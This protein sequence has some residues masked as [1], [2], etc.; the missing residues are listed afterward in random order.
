MNDVNFQPPERRIGDKEWMIRFIAF[1]VALVFM[2][3]G[4]FL[5]SV[6]L[7]S[8]L[9]ASISFG[10]G[11]IGLAGALFVG[12]N[13]FLKNRSN[14]RFNALSPSINYRLK[15]EIK[16][17][18]ASAKDLASFVNDKDRWN[19]FIKP[20]TD[21][22]NEINEIKRLYNINID[23]LYNDKLKSIRQSLINRFVIHYM[24]AQR[25]GH[26]IKPKKKVSLDNLDP[27]VNDINEDS[28]LDFTEKDYLVPKYETV[29]H[30][31]FEE[32]DSHD[33]DSIY[34]KDII[35]PDI[36]VEDL[37]KNPS[38]QRTI[39]SAKSSLRKNEPNFTNLNHAEK[40]PHEIKITWNENLYKRLAKNQI[41]VQ[42]YINNENPSLIMDQGL[43][44]KNQKTRIHRNNIAKDI[45]SEKLSEKQRFLI[46]MYG[47]QKTPLPAQ[48]RD[49]MPIRKKTELAS[50]NPRSKGMIKR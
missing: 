37:T 16:R 31:I 11:A 36:V 13:T 26:P 22:Q 1:V 29:S 40:L 5:G 47:D 23:D 2:L 24:V 41:K 34:S 10:V 18:V 49:L 38:S 3:E 6:V 27:S 12:V 50:D 39:Q 35:L 21:L 48:Y 14:N 15:N 19:E 42:N 8:P 4:F 28:N 17:K 20:S 44:R 9:I 45:L 7:A 33:D 30:N 32:S 46:N 43:T 25:I